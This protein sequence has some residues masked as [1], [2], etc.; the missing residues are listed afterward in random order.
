MKPCFVPLEVKT[1]NRRNHL[2]D[3][4]IFEGSRL[5]GVVLAHNPETAFMVGCIFGAMRPC[6]K[7]MVNIE[8]SA[9]AADLRAFGKA[10]RRKFP[11][12]HQIP[13]KDSLF[14]TRPSAT[15]ASSE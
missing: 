10:T 7:V 2:D 15:V 8:V 1:A 12:T 3:V 5:F 13:I 14:D 11:S 9:S 4:V 6:G